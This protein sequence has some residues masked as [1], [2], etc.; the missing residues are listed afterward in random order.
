MTT[1]KATRAKKSVKKHTSA[2]VH[3][4]KVA[5][6]KAENIETTWLA[7]IRNLS[8]KIYRPKK[9]YNTSVNTFDKAIERVSEKMHQDPQTIKR[10]MGNASLL[11]VGAL[12]YKFASSMLRK[13][14]KTKKQLAI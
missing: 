14:H 9:L 10:W 4:V 2:A 5:A 12:A 6:K 11:A 3:K 7:K 8:K 13:S 1:S